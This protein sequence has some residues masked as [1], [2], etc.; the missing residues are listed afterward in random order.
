MPCLT[1]KDSGQVWRYSKI[2][3]NFSGICKSRHSCWGSSWEL[4]S[5][6]SSE[7]N[8]TRTFLAQFGWLGCKACWTNEPTL[9]M[10]S[11]PHIADMT[12]RWNVHQ[13]TWQDWH[14]RVQW[15]MKLYFGEAHEYWFYKVMVVKCG[16]SRGVATSSDT[17][18]SLFLCRGQEWHDI[19]IH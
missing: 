9:W 19:G 1:V 6:P 5:C 15:N 13:Y 12:L 14:N 7:G 11:N 10:N 16:S 3:S 18:A 17:C 4:S 2:C 8:F